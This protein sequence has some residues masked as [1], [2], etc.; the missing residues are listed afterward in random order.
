MDAV[1]TCSDLDTDP[2]NILES[3]KVTFSS[4]CVC[5]CVCVWK[6]NKEYIKKKK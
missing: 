2:P 1:V 6:Q 3:D 5:V 4:V